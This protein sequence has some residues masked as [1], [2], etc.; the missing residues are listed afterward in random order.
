MF[1]I[2]M[3]KKKTKREDGSKRAKETV[4]KLLENMNES[5][6]TLDFIKFLQRQSRV[7]FYIGFVV[8]IIIGLILGTLITVA[9]GFT[10]NL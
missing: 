6:M 1:P 2:I 3:A 8:G 4:E 10:I 7:K 9:I 5:G